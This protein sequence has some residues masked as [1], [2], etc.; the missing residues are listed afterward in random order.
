MTPLIGLTHV[1][2]SSSDVAFSISID[3]TLLYFAPP[4]PPQKNCIALGPFFCFCTW[5]SNLLHPFLNWCRY[6]TIFFCSIWIRFH[7]S[8]ILTSE[9]PTQR[10]T[11]AMNGKVEILNFLLGLGSIIYVVQLLLE[12]KY[13][14]NNPQCL[15]WYKWDLDFTRSLFWNYSGIKFVQMIGWNLYPCLRL[16][17]PFRMNHPITIKSIC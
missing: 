4:T 12:Q 1:V 2:Y 10:P 14:V 17:I 8:M 11:T 9:R 13:P 15:Q 16:G 3:R 5:T 6:G 7:V